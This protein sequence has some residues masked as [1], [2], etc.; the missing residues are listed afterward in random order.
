MKAKIEIYLKAKP[1]PLVLTLTE[2]YK[3][4]DWLSDVSRTLA[5]AEEVLHVRFTAARR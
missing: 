5:D 2:E 1:K 3:S 4:E